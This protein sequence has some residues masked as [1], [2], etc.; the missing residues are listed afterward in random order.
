MFEKNRINRWKWKIERNKQF[1][2]KINAIN[3]CDYNDYEQIRWINEWLKILNFRKRES[4]WIETNCDRKVQN[5][6]RNMRRV[7]W[8]QKTKKN[9]V[10]K[11]LN[12]FLRV[13]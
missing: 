3:K 9:K 4:I 2:E 10:T 5:E 8:N 1:C 13:N 11:S 6:K 7:E 12:H